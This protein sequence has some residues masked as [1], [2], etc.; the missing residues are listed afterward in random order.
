MPLSEARRPASPWDY[1]RE[2]ER[3]LPRDRKG[4]IL[5]NFALSQFGND[6]RYN[7]HAGDAL[8]TIDQDNREGL[9]NPP[10]PEALAQEIEGFLSEP[11]GFWGGASALILAWAVDHGRSIEKG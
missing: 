7:K 4:Y 11:R 2:L 6:D 3:E 8:A 5:A 9:L 10:L 1:A